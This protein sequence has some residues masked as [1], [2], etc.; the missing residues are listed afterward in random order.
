MLIFVSSCFKYFP[1]KKI[2][3]LKTGLIEKNSTQKDGNKNRETT[4]LKFLFYIWIQMMLGVFNY[5][6]IYHSVYFSEGVFHSFIFIYDL[7]SNSCEEIALSLQKL[8]KRRCIFKVSIFDIIKEKENVPTKRAFVKFFGNVTITHLKK[9]A[10]SSV[11]MVPQIH[12]T[13]IW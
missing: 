4:C 3:T 12:I 11:C 1:V 7:Q 6:S 13:C 5:D 9:Q 10:H 8:Q 2:V